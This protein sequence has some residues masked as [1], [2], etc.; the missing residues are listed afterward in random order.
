MK[1]F[2]ALVMALGITGSL[3]AQP[4]PM[5]I[6]LSSLQEQPHYPYSP[7][8]EFLVDYLVTDFNGQVWDLG[9]IMDSGKPIYFF[10]Y[11]QYD[12]LLGPGQ[13]VN[14]PMLDFYNQYG[15]GGDTSCFVFITIEN[16]LEPAECNCSVVNQPYPCFGFTVAWL[17]YLRAR[18]VFKFYW[19]PRQ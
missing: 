14:G 18:V 9:A 12:E 8:C 2:F 16:I 4:M 13:F 11:G 1:Y 7:E 5:P 17:L 15:Q 19:L 10:G 6:I 3:V